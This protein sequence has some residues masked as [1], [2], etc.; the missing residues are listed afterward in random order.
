MI[1]GA[2]KERLEALQ[3]RCVVAGIRHEAH[4]YW[5]ALASI[6]AAFLLTLA[7]LDVF[8]WR[9]RPPAFAVALGPFTDKLTPQAYTHLVWA[10]AVGWAIE[11]ASM[12]CTIW[13]F[14]RLSARLMLD[15]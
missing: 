8:I 13:Y 7:M 9:P 1:D 3:E 15:R 11:F 5:M 14:V 6:G 12:A 10:A 2:E 4:T